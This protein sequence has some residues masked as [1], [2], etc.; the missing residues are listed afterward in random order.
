MTNALK[1]V[2]MQASTAEM[3]LPGPVLT[4]FFTRYRRSPLYRAS[5]VGRGIHIIV[6]YINY[7]KRTADCGRVLAIVSGDSST[8]YHPQRKLSR[9]F[10]KEVNE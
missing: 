6:V 10:F 4:V 8:V 2:I 3:P 9:K 5:Y 1:G 7:M